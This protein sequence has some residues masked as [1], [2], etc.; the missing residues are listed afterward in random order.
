MQAMKHKW[1]LCGHNNPRN[2][3]DQLTDLRLYFPELASL[4]WVDIEQLPEHDL[5]PYYGVIFGAGGMLYGESERRMAAVV[6]SG[7]PTICFGVGLNYYT[8]D[9]KVTYPDWLYRCLFT[10]LRD[11]VGNHHIWVPCPSCL[12]PAFDD[13]VKIPQQG[14]RTATYGHLLTPSKWHLTA[15]KQPSELR[16][17]LDFFAHNDFILADSYHALYWCRLLGYRAFPSASVTSIKFHTLG[18]SRLEHARNA[19][20]RAWAKVKELL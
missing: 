18:Y 17:V 11:T 14:E 1:L 10:G 9:G 19:V 4:D 20:L 8:D 12:H 15:N 6:E 16:A 2:L 5:S 7:K 13:Y 3:G